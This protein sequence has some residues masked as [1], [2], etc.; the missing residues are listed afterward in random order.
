[1]SFTPALGLYI[2]IP[3]CARKCP[4]CDFNTYAGLESLHDTTVDALCIE[5]E[6]WGPRLAGRTVS[7]VFVGGG[8]PTVLTAAQLE[9]IFGAV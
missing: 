3:F 9:R 7:T 2:H 5:M 4:Y 8:T 1:M 6:R